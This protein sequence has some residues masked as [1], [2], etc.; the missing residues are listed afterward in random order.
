MYP[1][2]YAAP[3]TGLSGWRWQGPHSPHCPHLPAAPSCLHE[4]ICVDSSAL[5][6]PA[7]LWATRWFVLGEHQWPG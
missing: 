5:W 3:P 7:V 1:P 4:P 2:S 6:S